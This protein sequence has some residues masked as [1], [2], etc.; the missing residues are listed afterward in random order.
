MTNYSVFLKYTSGLIKCADSMIELVK[1]H[2]EIFNEPK[3]IQELLELCE[4]SPGFVGYKMI[5]KQFEYCGSICTEY[6]LVAL[7]DNVDDAVYV[8]LLLSLE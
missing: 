4:N 3:K 5:D 8:K 7:Y 6:H 1:H 2:Q